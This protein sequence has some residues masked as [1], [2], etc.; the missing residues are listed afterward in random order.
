MKEYIII[1]AEIKPKEDDDL[2]L[3]YTSKIITNETSIKKMVDYLSKNPPIP[4]ATIG[5]PVSS[6]SSW[7][8]F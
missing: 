8:V 4:K 3:T 6:K 7:F 2:V 5:K 1:S